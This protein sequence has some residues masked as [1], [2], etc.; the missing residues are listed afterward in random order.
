MHQD[1]D[2]IEALINKFKDT[3]GRT[4]DYQYFTTDVFTNKKFSGAAIAVFPDARGLTDQSMLQLAR[5]IN[6]LQTVFVDTSTTAEHPRLKVFSPQGE[7]PVGSH[8]SVAA[9]HVLAKLGASTEARDA[10]VFEHNS[11]FIKAHVDKVEQQPVFTQISLSTVPIIDHY[12][13]TVSEIADML[14]L[15][16]NDIEQLRYNSMQVATDTR[17]LIVPLRSLKALKQ[18][19]FNLAAWGRTS[20]A[21]SLVEEILL[22]S[23]E[24]EQDIANF[25]FRLVG[26]DIANHSNPAVGSAIPAFSAYLCADKKTR[27]GTHMY[28]VERGYSVSRQSILNVEFDH[29]D[30]PELTVRIGGEVVISTQGSVSVD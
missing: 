23:T 8:T 20:A 17:Y 7:A 11:G 29:K 30:E 2:F 26:P 24:T 21:S 4:M 19:K 25:H 9:A 15:T 1:S 10:F 5:E 18:A 13:P 6:Q 16:I 27:T 12:T 3:E 28:S 14:M 22:F